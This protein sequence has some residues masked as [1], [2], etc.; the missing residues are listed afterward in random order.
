[1]RQALQ[2]IEAEYCRCDVRRSRGCGI[3]AIVQRALDEE[4]DELFQLR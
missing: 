1:M 4:A 2:E 3:H